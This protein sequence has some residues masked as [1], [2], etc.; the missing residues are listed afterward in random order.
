TA[1][2]HLCEH[3]L[4]QS[5]PYAQVLAAAHYEGPLRE[6]IHRFKYR[7]E[8]GLERPLGLLLGERFEE[9]LRGF[10]PD[11]VVPVPLHVER[12]RQRSYNQALLLARRLGRMLDLTVAE[13]ALQRTRATDSQQRLSGRGRRANLRGA[14]AG[15]G[16]LAD[17]RVLLV[18]DV[19]TTGATVEECSRE[20][21]RCG[22]R[23]VLVVVLGRSAVGVGAGSRP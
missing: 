19:M 10:A 9:R 16:K 20:L 22:A 7:G 23:D 4:R 5:P 3:C 11:L 14:F 6:A 17:R 21:R 15:S 2:D 1:V 8:V 18:D 13:Q 12:L